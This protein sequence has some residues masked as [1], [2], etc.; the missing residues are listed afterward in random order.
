M[1]RCKKFFVVFVVS[2]LK[3]V[4]T[5]KLRKTGKRNFFK[6]KKRREKRYTFFIH[7]VLVFITHTHNNSTLVHHTP[8]L[9]F[10]FFLIVTHL[11]VRTTQN[12]LRLKLTIK[13]NKQLINQEQNTMSTT[14][15]SPKNIYRWQI[16]YEKML[17]IICCQGNA[18]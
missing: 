7:F 18:N 1:K 3:A 8:T 2:N 4:M 11:W 5:Q 17:Q 6:E 13:Q 14:D 10:L 16:T 12:K 15:I 9:S